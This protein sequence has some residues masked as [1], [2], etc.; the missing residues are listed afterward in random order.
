MQ[1]LKI[2]VQDD[3]A[4]VKRRVG[5]VLDEV[6][7][8]RD[9][10][11]GARGRVFILAIAAGAPRQNARTTAGRPRS[12]RFTPRHASDIAKRATR[13]FLLEELRERA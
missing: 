12:Q 7:W 5:E 2:C 10:L 13:S 3:A 1:L 6:E 9:V 8:D 4:L 11:L